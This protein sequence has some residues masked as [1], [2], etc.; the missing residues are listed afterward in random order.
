MYING[1]P[2]NDK[3]TKQLLVKLEKM[4]IKH[5]IVNLNEEVSL[6]GNKMTLEGFFALDFSGV[7]DVNVPITPFAVAD[8]KIFNGVDKISEN[9]E[10]LEKKFGEHVT[11]KRAR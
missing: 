10:Y 5:K 9:L 6:Y 4:K 3:K 11:V 7:G 8:D 1:S 2:E